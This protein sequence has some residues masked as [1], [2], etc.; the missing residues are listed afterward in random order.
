MGV[1]NKKYFEFDLSDFDLKDEYENQT[2]NKLQMLWEEGCTYV[3]EDYS[4]WL[5]NKLKQH[6]SLKL[7]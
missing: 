5:E 7:C 1:K 4:N 6:R 3:D 2:G